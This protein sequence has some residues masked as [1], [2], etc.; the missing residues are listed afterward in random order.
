MSRCPRALLISPA[1]AC[2]DSRSD[3]RERQT[4]AAFHDIYAAVYS[5]SKSY[6]SSFPADQI[7]RRGAIESTTKITFHYPLKGN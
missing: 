1:P 7:I 2:P 4:R 3:Y 6:I 5:E